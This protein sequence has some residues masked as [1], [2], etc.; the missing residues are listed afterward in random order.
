MNSYMKPAPGQMCEWFLLCTRPATV[1]IEHP[2]VGPVPAC[3]R[4]EDWYKTMSAQGRQVGHGGK[5]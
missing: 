4:C 5:A 3:S 2:I 1:F